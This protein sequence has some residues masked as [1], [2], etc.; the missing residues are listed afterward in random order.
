MLAMEAQMPKP[1][2]KVRTTMKISQLMAKVIFQA[3]LPKTLLQ[4]TPDNVP[5]LGQPFFKHAGEHLCRLMLAEASAEGSAPLMLCNAA[6]WNTRAAL[7][8]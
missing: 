3:F 4:I 6:I 8:C 7:H 2:P 1:P 5:E